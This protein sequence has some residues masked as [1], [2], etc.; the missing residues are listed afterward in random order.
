MSREQF[1]RFTIRELFRWFAVM[2]DRQK[3]ALDLATFQA[4]QTVRV[5]WMTK[6]KKGRMPTFKAVLG[7]PG[8]RIDE[9]TSPEKARALMEVLAARVGSRV[10]VVKKA[11]QKG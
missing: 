6:A 11:K 7:K 2:Q 8:D 10:Q 1:W 9:H 3:Q 4:Y 5:H